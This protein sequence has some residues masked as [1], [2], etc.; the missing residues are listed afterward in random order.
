MTPGRCTRVEPSDDEI[1]AALAARDVDTVVRL[2][3]KMWHA[4]PTAYAAELLDMLSDLPDKLVC[5]RPRLL[6][7]G[8]VAHHTRHSRTDGVL[9][10]G[11]LP[12]VRAHGRRYARSAAR[13]TRRED[14]LTAGVW[15]I[16]SA[17]LSG[18]YAEADRVAERVERVLDAHESPE[19]GPWS[20]DRAHSRPG[21][22]PLHRGVTAALAGELDVAVQHLTRAHEEAGPA[23]YQHFAG[24]EAASVA[25]LVTA[26]QGHHDLA[27]TWLRRQEEH[28]A[29]PEPLRGVLTHGGA[30]ARAL[31]AI[32]ALDGAAAA[33]RL[34]AAGDAADAG[35]LWP[36]LAA[37]RADHDTLFDDPLKGLL[38][39]E[40][41]C[42]AHGTRVDRCSTAGHRITRARADLLARA[43]EGTQVLQLAEAHPQV[44]TLAVPAATVHLAADDHHRAVRVA[45]RAV[46]DPGVTPRDAASLWLVLAAAQLRLGRVDDALVAAQTA[47]DLG[48]VARFPRAVALLP[49][50][51]REALTQAG[52]LRAADVL[53]ALPAPSRDVSLVRLTRR[54]DVVLHA[55]AEGGTMPAV[56]RRLGVSVHTVRSQA[57]SLYAKLGATSRA[58]ALARA[59]HLGLVDRDRDQRSGSPGRA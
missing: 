10:R 1:R 55:L 43:G 37:A 54:E 6:L 2:A 57:S 4:L 17:R 14:V 24:V 49:E 59:E 27:R 9:S 28:G 51:D 19:P 22:L 21:L 34:D 36:F 50:E 15:A 35:E 29:V 47:D 56:A 7:A 13:F 32:D 53:P 16:V 3:D 48:L 41:A 11:V 52:A 46:R 23:P 38:R 5:N 42:F 31:L 39:L 40:E 20:P 58:E 45:A 44:V 18:A 26:A 8:L 30:I 25:A 33:R 12:A